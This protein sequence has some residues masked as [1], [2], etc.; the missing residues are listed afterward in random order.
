MHRLVGTAVLLVCLFVPA[1]GTAQQGAATP[2][3]ERLWDA[4]IDGDTVALA[5]ALTAG[6][7]IDSLDT[8]ENQNGRRAL[9]WAAW[10]DHADAVR[11]LLARGAALEGRN[12]TLNT[13]LHHAAE[14]GALHSL[15]ALLAA[16]ADPNA[17][18]LNG[19]R[20]VDVARNR[21]YPEAVDLLERA[22]RG[23]R[24]SAQ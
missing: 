23:V 4:A 22:M 24:P 18:N 3:Q 12:R 9:N 6:A 21:E 13:P 7:V 5:R 11:F 14:A 17:V 2:A 10:Y 20:P 1:R 8:R 15:R 16:G 19:N